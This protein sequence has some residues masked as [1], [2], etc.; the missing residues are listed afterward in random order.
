MRKRRPGNL[1][2]WSLGS[3]LW[4]EELFEPDVLP[5]TDQGPL[6]D[7]QLKKQYGWMDDLQA[8]QVRGAMQV[9]GRPLTIAEQQA[10]MKK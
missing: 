7:R 4:S 9:M 2:N 3:A 5:L 1:S 10:M 8:R 6:T